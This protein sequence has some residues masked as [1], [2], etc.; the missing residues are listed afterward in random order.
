[1]LL[2]LISWIFKNNQ[3]INI[4]IFVPKILNLETSRIKFEAF[5][6]QAR[7]F[8][9][10][11]LRHPNYRALYACVEKKDGH[12]CLRSSFRGKERRVLHLLC[13]LFKDYFFSVPRK[14]ETNT[15]VARFKLIWQ[16]G[17]VPLCYLW[18]F[19]KLECANKNNNDDVTW[20]GPRRRMPKGNSRRLIRNVLL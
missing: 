20:V 3:M 5:A 14:K 6:I 19:E 8:N 12:S 1:M 2:Y 15:K 4:W 17:V 18:K 10:I 16:R 9:L 13:S 11:F 7:K